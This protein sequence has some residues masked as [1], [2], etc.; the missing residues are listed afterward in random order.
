MSKTKRE[1]RID[2][3][4]ESYPLIVTSDQTERVIAKVYQAECAPVISA[5][6]ELFEALLPF[7][8]LL[9]FPDEFAGERG[10]F[11]VEVADIKR[12]LKA[13]QKAKGGAK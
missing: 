2:A 4:D 11:V 6:P 10:E 7:A 13:V 8:G 12:A 1:W 3:R 5:A 9:E